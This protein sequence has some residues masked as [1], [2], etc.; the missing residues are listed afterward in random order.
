MTN[1]RQDGTDLLQEVMIAVFFFFLHN[2]MAE[3]HKQQISK[4]MKRKAVSAR[5]GTEGKDNK[6][7]NIYK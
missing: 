5:T 2:C 1:F 4:S 7:V 3:E 6:V